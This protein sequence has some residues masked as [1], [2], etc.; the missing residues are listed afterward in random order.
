MKTKHYIL[1]VS[2]LILSGSLTWY[3]IDR[4]KNGFKTRLLKIAKAELNKWK[5][6]TESSPFMADTLLEYWQ[7]VGKIFTKDQMQ[8]PT[9][10][11]SFPWSSAFISYLFKKAGAKSK[12]PYSAAH[13]TYFQFAKANRYNPKAD[14]IGYKIN[15]YAPKAGDIVVF[16]RE[17]GKGYDSTGHFP[18]H[19]ELVLKAG[20]GYILTEGG[21]VGNTVEDTKYTTDNKGFL[22]TLER[23]FFM[24]IENN[25]R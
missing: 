11:A 10:Q 23:P 18:A 22:T 7:S 3:F 20:K 1:I 5:N 19:G 8:D 17:A 24:V 9:F 14:L 2:L 15:E 16:S 13:S 21:N 4:H 6:F 12:F 25:I